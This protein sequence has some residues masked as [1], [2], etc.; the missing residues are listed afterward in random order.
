MLALA[1]SQTR[2][3]L[4]CQYQPRGAGCNRMQP[5]ESAL[6]D[7][8]LSRIGT[9][10]A[11]DLLLCGPRWSEEGRSRKGNLQTALERGPILAKSLGCWSRCGRTSDLQTCC[12][13][14]V[15]CNYPA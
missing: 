9:K 6:G 7:G 3:S 13:V 14:F 15:L 5:L 2:G 12:S 1:G 11:D 4:R 8:E 10:L